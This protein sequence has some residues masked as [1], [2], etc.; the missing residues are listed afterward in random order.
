MK[1]LPVILLLLICIFVAWR[2]FT[3]GVWLTGWDTLHPE[4]DFG[5]NFSR[6]FNG[7]WRADQG[8]G[9]L[10]AHAHM[11]ELPRLVWLWLLH[12]AVP[13]ESVRYL[14]VLLCLVLGPVGVYLFVWDGICHRSESGKWVGCWS[15]LLYLLNLYTVQHFIVVFEMFAIQYAAIGW[16]FW[17]GLRAFR[18]G[19]KSNYGWLFVVALLSS[20]QAYASQ[21]WW[22]GTACFC[23][24]LGLYALLSSNVRSMIRN[25]WLVFAIV[26]AANGFWLFPNTY[27]LIRGNVVP[28]QALINQLFSPDSYL[29]NKEF[30][31]ISGLV[32]MK[33]FL[34][35]WDT[36]NPQTGFQPIMGEWLIWSDQGVVRALSW[37]TFIC[38]VF[39]Y[40]VTILSKQI[41][42]E[43]R[44]VAISL[45]PIG[46][47]TASALLTN[48]QP[49]QMMFDFL[50]T[51]SGLI[52]EGL[53][54]PFTK[55]S[56][57]YL[58]VYSIGFGLAVGWVT[59]QFV[60]IIRKR[61]IAYVVMTCFVTGVLVTSVFPVMRGKLISDRLR[62][63]IP[64]EY[65]SLFQF[66]QR[67]P[68]DRVALLPALS[69]WG[70]EYHQWGYEGPGFLWFGMP[71]PVL[72][73]DFDR[74]SP[75]NEDFYRQI[76][77]AVAR[78]DQEL[79]EGTLRRFQVGW[80]V[81]DESTILPGM[82]V[83]AS[84]I[85]QTTASL[86]QA[87]GYTQVWSEGTVKVFDTGVHESAIRQYASWNEIGWSGDYW[88]I[89]PWYGQTIPFVERN[90][91]KKIPV[92]FDLRNGLNPLQ[93]EKVLVAKELFEETEGFSEAKNCDRLQ[94]GSVMRILLGQGRMYQAENGAAVCDYFTYPSIDPQF[95]YLLRIVS[96]NKGGRPLK[97]SVNQ[98]NSYRVVAE[99]LF[100]PNEFEHW[101]TIDGLVG[102]VPGLVVNVESRS[103]GVIRSENELTQ[104]EWYQVPVSEQVIASDLPQR[105]G[106]LLAFNQGY[107][108]GWIGWYQGKLLEHVRVNGWQNGWILP[109]A[110]SAEY[111]VRSTESNQVIVVFWPQYLEWLG[112]G[113]MGITM[114]ILMCT[115]RRK[116]VA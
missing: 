82:D 41:E 75:Y 76:E 59:E 14:S 25:G 42:K 35:D 80:L 85:K 24:F 43:K 58:L 92:R 109:E 18:R 17:L 31:T 51:R 112:F 83:D 34:F 73:R 79:F 36:Y 1:R 116:D 104:I 50:R 60:K 27:F 12:F 44:V 22:V 6:L 56:I 2:N 29:K 86:I 53:R 15:G 103:F 97:V 64:H 7:V 21:L 66:M 105:N 102:S 72:T 99:A 84:Q 81:W 38:V 71:Q 78:E 69:K 8:V 19:T 11:S 88:R 107:N 91:G 114:I 30:G 4:F 106:V 13:I 55:V 100:N 101:L 3:P 74:W 9:A 110:V 63:S 94:R 87:S 45:V 77:L 57:V 113:V 67:Q 28:K 39:G 33:N 62:Q 95:R 61:L 108:Q 54:T 111:G 93:T 65:I 46:L 40:T 47:L 5:L 96:T 68:A 48:T 90:G 16:L 89:D 32:S 52:E 10:A 98:F 70:W 20:A 115:H 37:I 26:I 23:L 49:F